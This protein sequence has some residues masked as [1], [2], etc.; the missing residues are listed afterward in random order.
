MNRPNGRRRTAATQYI[1]GMAT[2]V[3]YTGALL[4]MA[5]TV[6]LAVWWWLR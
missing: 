5:A 1:L 2:E 4:A 6:A 3:L